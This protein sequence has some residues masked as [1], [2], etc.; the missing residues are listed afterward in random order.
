MNLITIFAYCL[1]Y[2]LSKMLL[3]KEYRPQPIV[4]TVWLCAV[5]RRVLRIGFVVP[6]FFLFFASIKLAI[7]FDN[8]WIEGWN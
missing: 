3:K 5:S 8:F 7:L 2:T 4:L 6:R 1:Y